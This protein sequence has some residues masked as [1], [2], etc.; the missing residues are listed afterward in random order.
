MSIGG[1][2]MY[3]RGFLAESVR[4]LTGKYLG[5]GISREVYEYGGN[6]EF[7]VKI[8]VEGNYI[9]QNAMEY[10]FWEECKIH[11]WAARWLAP[12]IRISANGNF[13]IQER[14]MPVTLTELE[15]KLPQIPVW[16][17]DCKA[18]NWGRLPN[19]KIVCHDYGT[20]LSMG[21][22]LNRKMHKADWYG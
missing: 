16:L 12:C 3:Q 10:N 7:V 4:F 2:E 5:K 11:K 9:F 1:W 21:N 8:E 19:G 20:N 18:D 6:T 17:T 14:T 15:K 22:G 13:M